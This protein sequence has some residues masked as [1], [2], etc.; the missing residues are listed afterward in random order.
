[1]SRTNGSI[2]TNNDSKPNGI[3][4]HQ[5][6]LPFETTDADL[7]KL[8]IYTA[9]M[10]VEMPVNIEAKKGWGTGKGSG[11]GKNAKSAKKSSSKGKGGVGMGKGKLSEQAKVTSLFDMQVQIESYSYPTWE[12]CEV[13]LAGR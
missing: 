10:Q 1:M 2:S 5:K 3:R 4:K 13:K 11:T 12:R 6:P 7:L 8:R 9:P